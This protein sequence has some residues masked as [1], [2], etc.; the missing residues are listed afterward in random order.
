MGPLCAPMLGSPR[1]WYQ[2]LPAGELRLVKVQPA[3]STSSNPSVNTAVL[4]CAAAASVRADKPTVS[5]LPNVMD[6]P[7]LLHDRPGIPELAFQWNDL[8]SSLNLET[9]RHGGKELF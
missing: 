1:P 7:L 3:C 5:F 9:Y 8:T 6:T 2:L 4:A